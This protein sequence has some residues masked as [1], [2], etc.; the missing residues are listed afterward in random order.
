MFLAVGKFENAITVGKENTF[1]SRSEKIKTSKG[2]ST[3]Y[4]ILFSLN[5]YG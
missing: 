1:E 3:K 4:A 5:T 2:K